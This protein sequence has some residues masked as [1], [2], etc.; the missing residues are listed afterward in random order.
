M[1]ISE[2]VASCAIRQYGA[3]P[4]RKDAA[5]SVRDVLASLMSRRAASTRARAHGALLTS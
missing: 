1:R 4:D 2:E 3:I 5:L